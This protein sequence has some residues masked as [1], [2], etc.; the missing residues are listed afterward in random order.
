MEES[1]RGLR[2]RTLKGGKIILSEWTVL[3][4]TI[5]D[6]SEGGAR[7]EFG[8]LTELPKEFNL[9]LVSENLIVPA[10]MAWQRG[11]MVGVRFTGPGRPASP[12]K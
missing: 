9:L 1:R 11:K 6:L 10:A 5:R 4:C 7:L 2:R 3:D 8:A 12:R